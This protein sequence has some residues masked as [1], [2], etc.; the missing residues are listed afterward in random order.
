MP[1]AAT[2]GSTSRR[3][4]VFAEAASAAVAM[5]ALTVEEAVHGLGVHGSMTK[6]GMAA[7][8]ELL[9]VHPP[10]PPPPPA[11][12][13]SQGQGHATQAALE[14]LGK[15]QTLGMHL[16]ELQEEDPR[17]VF[18][19]RRIS[20]MG[21]RSQ[22]LLATH[23]SHHGEVRR[24]LVAHS[25]V[26]PFRSTGTKPRIRPG[27]L[28]FIVMATA[29]SVA[30]ILGTGKEQTVAGCG[31][32][33]EPFEQ[34]A[35]P[36]ECRAASTAE[37]TSTGTGN[38]GGTGSGSGSGSNSN[39]SEKELGSGTGSNGSEKGS[40]KSSREECSLQ[41]DSIVAEGGSTDSQLAEGSEF[42]SGTEGAPSPSAEPA[43]VGTQ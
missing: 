2:A 11:Q 35:T 26:K 17:C 1:A 41:K 10:P 4:P 28:G 14:R 5:P 34:T 7:V 33:V 12:S 21:F 3:S 20:S 39:G 29:E 30:S 36:S 27:S 9:P 16:T 37:S 31:I 19:A 22:E 43:V 40:D 18:I 15:K 32:L 24:V 25:K 6:P 13:L 8:P 38:T 42:S 23:Y